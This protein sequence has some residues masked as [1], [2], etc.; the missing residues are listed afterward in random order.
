VA[1]P[2]KG[3]LPLLEALEEWA[4]PGALAEPLCASGEWV[5][6]ARPGSRDAPYEK[7]PTEAWSIPTVRTHHIA[8][9]GELRIANANLMFRCD[10]RQVRE[11]QHDGEVKTFE[12]LVTTETW[13][14]PLFIRVEIGPELSYRERE[15]AFLEWCAQERQRDPREPTRPRRRAKA[16]ELGLST[17]IADEPVPGTPK[18]RRQKCAK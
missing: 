17:A 15:R 18:G 9:P 8:R 16:K 6:W 5:C 2:P 12:R 14:D 10:F 11:K 13:Y 3:A 7:L 4:E 1:G